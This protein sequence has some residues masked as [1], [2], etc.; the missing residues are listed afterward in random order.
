MASAALVVLSGLPAGAFTSTQVIDPLIT[1]VANTVGTRTASFD[2][3]LRLASNP[4]GSATQPFLSWVNIQPAS[5]WQKPQEVIRITWDV[6]DTNGGVQIYSN[7]TLATA[8]P[9]FVDPTPGETSNPDSN[10]AGLLLGTS[11]QSS[12][13]LPV[14]WSIKG[15]VGQEPDTADPNDTGDPNSFQWLFLQDKETPSITWGPGDTTDAFTD[16]APYST[17]IKL[18]SIHFGQADGEFGVDSDKLAYVYFQA[19]FDTAGAQAQYKSNTFTLEAFI[20]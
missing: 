20:E 19:N 18:N 11:G 4:E 12:D 9:Q 3:E 7:N 15:D 5:G 13:T 16:G 10:P 8:V 1:A 6:T 2:A 14:A 17:I